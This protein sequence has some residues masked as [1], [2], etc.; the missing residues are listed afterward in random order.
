M[1][2]EILAIGQMISIAIAAVGTPGVTFWVM[3]KMSQQNLEAIKAGCVVCRGHL[4]E[5]LGCLDEEMDELG[6]RQ[7]TL[8]EETLP[9]KYVRTSFCATC[10]KERKEEDQR[11]HDRISGK[12]PGGG[13]YP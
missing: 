10:R 8:R 4:E 12:H 1:S 3:K 11:L 5:K 7:K 13:R 6:K 2:S 9:D